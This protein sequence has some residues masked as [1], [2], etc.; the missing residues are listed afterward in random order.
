MIFLLLLQVNWAPSWK[1]SINEV[2]KVSVQLNSHCM[3]GNRPCLPVSA[4]LSQLCLVIVDIFQSVWKGT[5]D[6]IA[7][8]QAKDNSCVSHCLLVPDFNTCFAEL[9]TFGLTETALELW[10]LLTP[11]SS[12]FSYWSHWMDHIQLCL[13]AVS[14][15][16]SQ[17][18]RL[19]SG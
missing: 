4:A 2:Y 17:I 11:L 14:L 18:S 15:Q 10:L 19:S 12:L 7:T 9:E 3:F 16:S 6:M 1:C 5:C 13:S 8:K